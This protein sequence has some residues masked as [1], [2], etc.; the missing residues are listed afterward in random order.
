MDVFYI[1]GEGLLWIIKFL[2]AQ[3]ELN[4]HYWVPISKH[5]ECILCVH[6]IKNECILLC[7]L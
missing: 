4:A 3:A 2:S 1:Y 6:L 5:R 7:I